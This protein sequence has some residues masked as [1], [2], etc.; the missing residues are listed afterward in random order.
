MRTSAVFLAI[1]LLLAIHPA[2]AQTTTRYQAPTGVVAP[3]LATTMYFTGGG[4]AFL[5]PVV[6]PNCYLGM[7]CRF[8]AGYVG[9]YM[10]YQLPDGTTATL[11]NF[12]G[13][14][15]PYKT[16]YVIAG[17]ASGTDSAGH[18]VKVNYVDVTMTITCRSGRGGGCNKVYTGGIMG[19]TVN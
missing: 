13:L 14:F 19:L 5:N 12:H 4:S 6:G 17:G 10:S 2:S 3:S 1:S 7:V 18:A 11:T 9:S 15:E 16:G 8:P